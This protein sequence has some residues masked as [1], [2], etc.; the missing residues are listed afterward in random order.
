MDSRTGEIAWRVPL[1]ISEALPAENQNTGRPGRASALITD[2]DL[3]FI[4]A[5]DDNRIRAL[6]ASNGEQLWESV[7]PNQGNANPMTYLGADRNQ[8]LAITATDELLV[9]ALPD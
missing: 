8:Y 7:L 3:L 4:A 6:R 1:G 5:T 2:T 9:Y